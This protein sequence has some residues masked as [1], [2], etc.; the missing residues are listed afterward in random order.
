MI[1]TRPIPASQTHALRHAVLRPH[2]T[3]D[4]MVYPGDETPGT[5]HFG[6]FVQGNANPVGIVTLSPEPREGVAWRL[7]GM[8]TDPSVRGLGAGVLL[9]QACIEHA[10][11]TSHPDAETDAHGSA[12]IWCNA[13]TSAIGFYE[14]C[15][16]IVVSEPF[17]IEGIGPHV[18]M[19]HRPIATT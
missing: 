18:V 9:V 1:I 5:M 2:Q 19:E 6:A 4:E 15:G 8:A 10:G 13:R 12:G 3:L 17:E 16:F 7:R 11:S 14:R